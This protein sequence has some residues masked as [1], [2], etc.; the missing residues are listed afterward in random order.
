[1]RPMRTRFAV[2]DAIDMLEFRLER[3]FINW[4]SDAAFNSAFITRMTYD[5]PCA[6]LCHKLLYTVR[7]NKLAAKIL[8]GGFDPPPIEGRRH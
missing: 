4:V 3:T 7:R 5:S 1:M 8:S 2:F 6:D